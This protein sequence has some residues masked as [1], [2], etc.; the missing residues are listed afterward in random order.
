MMTLKSFQKILML[1]IILG[2][3]AFAGPVSYSAILTGPSENP[4]NASPGTGTAQVII[5]VIAH[6]LS[7]SASFS[8]LLAN[9]S[10]A[11]IHCCATAPANVG[12]AVGAVGFPV[13][14]TGGVYAHVF[15]TSL[16]GTFGGAFRTANGGTAA[17][18]E[19]ALAAGLA[20][21]RAYFNIHT[22]A[23]P[24]GEIRGFFTEDVPEP[25]T[26]V[27]AGFALAGL[28]LRRRLR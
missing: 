27:L 9:V 16:D 4:P 17:G 22:S 13:G 7:V 26:F 15:N 21:G 10:A 25:A 12:V 19:A 28:A 2:S 18:A 11:H 14:V 8:G 20:A 1:G 6:T 5:D 23:F 24:G 3:V